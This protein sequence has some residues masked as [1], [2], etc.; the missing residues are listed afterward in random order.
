M[1]ID[2]HVHL[3]MREFGGD[4]DAVMERAAAA[5]VVEMLQICYDAGSI[6]ETV[7]LAERHPA[8]FGTAGIHPHDAKGWSAEIE[9]KIRSA[10]ARPKI[11]AVGEI[12]LDYYRD[13]SPR[14]AQ[15]DVFRRQIR[16][17]IEAGKP[18]VVHSREAFPDTIAI[19]REEG[20]GRVGGIFH[21]FPGGVDE[22]AAALAANFLVG[23]GGPLT[24]RSSRLPETAA[25]LPSSGFVLETDCPYLPPEPHRGKRNEPAYVAFVRDRLAALRGVEPADI[26][27]ASSASYRRL[28]HGERP[29]APSIAYAL[30]GNVYIN[31]TG[32]CTNACVYCP[33]LGRDRTLYGYNLALAADPSP[34]EM[35]DA[36]G[37]LARDAAPREIVFCGFGEPTCRLAD[38]LETARAL[39][40]LGV[41]LRL[42]TNGQGSVIARRDVVP[43]LAA[44]FDAVSVSLGAH[45]AAAY[46]SLCRPDRGGERT[47]DAVIDFI[48]R[49]SASKM[50]CTVTIV[51]HPDVNVET[52][53]ALVA[54]ISGAAFRLRRHQIP[55]GGPRRG[56]RGKTGV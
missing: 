53:R 56:D 33:R 35:A 40:G 29:P 11:L 47:F 5:G 28:M 16:I 26:E 30:K 20:A 1:L 42:D 17:A 8:V 55:A 54:A 36:A 18:I 25:R 43:D 13:L 27:R 19:L 3:N 10:L 52:A 39:R 45:A 51:D 46:A 41:P 2:S 12:G 50:Q 15:R 31:V 9:R 24:Y 23:I 4:L 22:A 21:A 38:V 34:R 49:A 37:A 7:S 14:D 32:S 48:R 44:V 6:D